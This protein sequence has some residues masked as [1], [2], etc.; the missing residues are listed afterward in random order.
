MEQHRSH[1]SHTPVNLS[2]GDAARRSRRPK[3]AHAGGQEAPD[4]RR[5]PRVLVCEHTRASEAPISAALR[6]VGCE[7]QPCGD[8]KILLEEL[9]RQPAD[10][11]IY[12]LRTDDPADLGT[13]EL[14]RRAAPA[15][16]L[17]LVASE[18]SLVTQQ[19]VQGLRP[20]FYMVR[21]ID[22]AELREVLEAALARRGRPAN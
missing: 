12:D 8:A 13:L 16:P 18:G 10:A 14:L 21:P 19:R 5:M 7:A 3:A 17:V 11:V 15:V 20:I 1:D 6:A 9:V 2:A 4:L 22:G